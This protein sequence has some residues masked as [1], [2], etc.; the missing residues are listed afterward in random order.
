M[1]NP[2]PTSPPPLA[3]LEAVLERIT[4]ANEETGYTV[5][6]VS[7]RGQWQRAAHHRGQP[8]GRAAGREP[9]PA[10]QVEE[11]S[12]VWPPVRGRQLHHRAPRHAAG[13]P[14]L[15]RL[16]PHQGHRPQ[17]G[18]AHRHPLCTGHPA[19]HRGGA[20]APHRGA[21]AGSQ[22][23]RQDQRRL[24]GAEGHQGGDG[25]PAGRRRL[26]QPGRPHLQDLPDAS[27]SVVKH[28]PYR[29]ASDVWG[30]GFKTA[31]KIAQSLG[32]PQTAQ[33]ASRRGCS[34]PSPRPAKRGTATC[35]RRRSSPR[36]RRS[37][38]WTRR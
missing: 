26:D 19:R 20:R 37:W 13:H 35:P 12:P 14:P 30:I 25:L 38:A 1:P 16:R 36:R 17:D 11:P 4:Y 6:R 7:A 24:G 15:S 33:S 32:I 23:H 2:T 27:I 34:T 22:A 28:E 21:W 8:A 18:R 3:T 29:L 31:D 5:A 9:A 10:G